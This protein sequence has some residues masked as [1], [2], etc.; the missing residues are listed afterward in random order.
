MESDKDIENNETLIDANMYYKYSEFE[1]AAPIYLKYANQ[2][3]SYA[4]YKLGIC[5]ANGQGVPANYEEAFKWYHKSAESGNCNAQCALGDC[6]AKGQGVSWNPQYSV[7][8]Y[9]KAADQGDRTGMLKLSSYY[10][11]ELDYEEAKK[12]SD[13]AKYGYTIDEL[14]QWAIDGDKDAQYELG[15]FCYKG[16][17]V[18]QNYIRAVEW[19]L[20]SAEQRHKDAQYKLG[21]CY[22]QGKGIQQNYIEA[23]KWFRKAAEQGQKDAQYEL[24]ICYTYGYGIAKNYDYAAEWF[25]KAAEQGV[26]NAMYELTEYY[27]YIRGNIEEAKRWYRRTEYIQCHE[28]RLSNDKNKSKK[29]KKN[30]FDETVQLV[31]DGGYSYYDDVTKE[32]KFMSFELDPNLTKYTKLYSKEIHPVAD[33]K[34]DTQFSVLNEDCLS[35]AKRVALEC[36]EVCLLN[37]SSQRFPG[38]SVI[39]GEGAQEEYLGI[40][41][42]YYRSLFQFVWNEERYGRY[43]IKIN[44]KEKYPL[45]DNF[46]GVYSPN[47][48]FFREKRAPNDYIFVKPWKSNIIAVPAVDSPNCIEHDGKRFIDESYIP[49]IKNRMRTIFRIAID[50]KQINLVLSAWGCGAYRNPPEHIAILFKEILNEDEFVGVFAIIIFAI[51][52]KDIANQKSNYNVF[53]KVFT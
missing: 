2:G 36:N 34:Y 5:Y 47:V 23:Q 1:K 14:F 52:E 30:V 22:A 10:K 7:E 11:E 42:D 17:G 45:D 51:I 12:W 53:R 38:G 25:H 6:Y 24:G 15:N 50:N 41:S 26:I 37:M 19:Y 40:C 9:H 13:K 18:S 29:D 4:Q 21:I 8:W 32:V 46:G 44:P 35:I 48:T 16:I 39:S 31:K 20:E 49:I 27:G 28:E 43:G 33:N 3:D